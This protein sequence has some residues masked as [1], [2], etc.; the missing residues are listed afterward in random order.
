TRAALHLTVVDL[1]LPALKALPQAA[2]DELLAAL[3]AV[4]NADRRVTVHE[5]VVLTL[6]RQQLA[7]QAKPPAGDRK[8][9]DLRDEVLV[10]LSLIAHAG[11]RS[12][13]SGARDEALRTAMS[14]GLAELGL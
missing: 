1:A 4:I 3:E 14:A 10:V 6:V 7:P 9:A 5:F 8:L 2:K 11:I 13:A 12:D